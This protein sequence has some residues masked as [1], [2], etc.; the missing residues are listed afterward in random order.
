MSK[1]VLPGPL[2][3]FLGLVLLILFG[4][5]GCRH[6]AILDSAVIYEGD[7]EISEW[8]GNGVIIKMNVVFDDGRPGW[9][10][11]ARF[12]QNYLANPRPLHCRMYATGTIEETEPSHLGDR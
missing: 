11:N 9:T 3:F 4:L 2:F 5:E 6:Q 7:C 1:Y 12:I 10:T 8:G